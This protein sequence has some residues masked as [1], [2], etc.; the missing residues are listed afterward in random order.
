MSSRLRNLR[1]YSNT[2]T[3]RSSAFAARHF[4]RTLTRY[5]APKV[6]LKPK[7]TIHY[8]EPYTVGAQPNQ[9]R[10]FSTRHYNPS[11]SSRRA[12]VHVEESKNNV[13]IPKGSNGIGAYHNQKRYFTTRFYNPIFR[14]TLRYVR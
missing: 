10:Y 8:N 6:V 7:I 4:N 5:T 2:Q 3:Q 9:K 11:I 13:I 1:T 14:R 12:N